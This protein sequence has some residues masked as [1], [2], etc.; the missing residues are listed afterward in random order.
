MVCDTFCIKLHTYPSASIKFNKAISIS[1]P[2]TPQISAPWAN[3]L[4]WAVSGGN[5]ANKYREHLPSGVPRILGQPKGTMGDRAEDINLDC[6]R[7]H[8]HT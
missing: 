4:P 8:V 5:M 7:G 2:S 3:A 6:F 1:S